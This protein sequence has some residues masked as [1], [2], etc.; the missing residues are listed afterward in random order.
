MASVLLSTLFFIISSSVIAKELIEDCKVV[1]IY[2]GDTLT[3][4]CST[5]KVK[6]RFYCI[7]TPEM[8]QS[9]WGKISRDYLRSISPNNV[10]L[11]IHTKDRYGRYVAEVYDRNMNL[12]LNLV[13]NG[14]AAVYPRYCKDTEYYS[15]QKG[16]KENNLGI[17]KTDGDQ[18]TP[19]LWR[20]LN[21]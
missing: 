12:N 6:V 11:H 21:H 9:P 18:Q 17:W 7:D 5:T 19:W 16:A 10:N 1:S 14:M 2:D 3:A 13:R 4:Y 8:R 20:K 15:A